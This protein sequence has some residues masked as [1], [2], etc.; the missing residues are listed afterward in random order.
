MSF[1]LISQPSWFEHNFSTCSTSRVV[2]DDS[3]LPS[4]STAAS[5]GPVKIRLSQCCPDFCSRNIFSNCLFSSNHWQLARCY[6]IFASTFF[7]RRAR[8]VVNSSILR[9]NVPYFQ[10]LQFLSDCKIFWTASFSRVAR[11]FLLKSLSAMLW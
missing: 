8:L 4:R 6:S 5:L 7:H 9:W 1:E 10:S 11:N 3:S 2:N